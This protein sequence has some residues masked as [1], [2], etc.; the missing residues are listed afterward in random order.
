MCNQNCFRLTIFVHFLYIWNI[1]AIKCLTWQIWLGIT[2]MLTTKSA[3]LVASVVFNSLQPHRQEYCLQA[4]LLEW[5]AISFSRGSSW[6]R[7]RIQVSY[8]SC[9]GKC[10]SHSLP[11][12]PSGSQLILFQ[13]NSH[14]L[15]PISNAWA[16]IPHC[17]FIAQ[18]T[19][20]SSTP[21][22]VICSSGTDILM[23]LK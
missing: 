19:T 10:R 7:D 23:V 8:V 22:E 11:L 12:A 1:L 5:V 13:Y 18:W 14:H 20:L 2:V 17:W 15:V 4:R 6:P 9:I 3:C 16:G 21:A